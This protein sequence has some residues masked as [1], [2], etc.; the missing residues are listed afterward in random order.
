MSNDVR[1]M[2]SLYVAATR[3]ALTE[4]T[5]RTF[6]PGNQAAIKEAPP[7]M[8]AAAAQ[9]PGT[10][11][12]WIAKVSEF[13]MLMLAMNQTRGLLRHAP[14]IGPVLSG[15]VTTTIG[16]TYDLI[17]AGAEEALRHQ[18]Q[19]ITTKL[20]GKTQLTNT[21]ML[22]LQADLQRSNRLLS[23]VSTGRKIV[24]DIRA[25]DND[26]VMSLIASIR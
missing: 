8:Q 17:A 3:Q 5:D 18:T 4:G 6:D 15:A 10:V 20:Q 7:A 21:E 23:A 22:E 9:L 1:S 2:T 14:V 13:G 25:D 16:A 24:T 11:D 12:G 19:V 26:A